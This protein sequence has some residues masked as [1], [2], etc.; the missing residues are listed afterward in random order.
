MEN[1]ADVTT[2]IINTINTIFENL[3]SSIDN[4]LYGVLDELV[5]V[6][7]NILNDKYFS[8]LFG[9]STANGILLIANSLLIGMVLFYASK[10][11]ISNFT[12]ERI[13]NPFQFIF[14]C[15]IFGI[16]MNCSFFIIE[17]ILGLNNNVCNLIKN[18]GEDLWG[19]NICF[20]NL[21]TE[22]ND[23]LSMNKNNIDIFTIDGIIKGTLTIS[24]LNLVFS[25]SLRYV[26]IKIFILI[27]PFAFLSLLL[28][29]TSSFFKS[30]YKNLFSLL[31]IQLIVS[32]VLL[33]LFSMDYS[34]QNLVNKFIYIGGIY[35]LIRANGI[36]RELFGGISTS[37]QSGV[38]S[39]KS[40]SK[41]S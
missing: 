8:K 9:T 38:S 12:Y 3:F 22:I 23:N 27:S 20:S 5:F 19:K 26:L 32:I 41:I 30:W 10:F 34:K 36:V 1:S 37:V 31:F 40:F 6:D 4:N 15:I 14:K 13:E 7:G 35:A 2:N 24:L 25:Y 21:I 18:I 16:C 39:L 28:E 17:Q 29:R 11:M 33:L